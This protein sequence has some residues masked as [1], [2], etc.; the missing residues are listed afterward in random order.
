MA[1]FRK[2]LAA[3]LEAGRATARDPQAEATA[4]VPAAPPPLNQRRMLMA[5]VQGQSPEALATSLP[6][7]Q[8]I[9]QEK[10][11]GLVLVTDQCDIALFQQ[12]GCVTEY[13]P[14]VTQLAKGMA[15]NDP[16]AY[17]DRRMGILMRKWEP[18]QV[19]PFGGAAQA[20]F[21]RWHQ[22]H[23]ARKSA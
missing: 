8:A 1:A 6:T 19:L 9:A 5:L 4:D 20:V 3:A 18:V 16:Q 12:P 23:P 13:L 15:R 17:C 10:G 7:L 14:S 2:R 11:Y 21:D 22:T